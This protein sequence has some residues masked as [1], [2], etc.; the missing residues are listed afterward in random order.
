MAIPLGVFTC[1]TGVSGSG[2]STLVH[3]VVGANLLRR[4][5]EML[6][7][8]TG[9]CRAIEG[10]EH[11]GRVVLVDQSPL[12]RTPRSTP[13]VYIGVFDK[14]RD[15]FADLP[16]SR[17]AGLTPGTFSFNSSG[18]RCERCGGT[19]FEK[20]EMQF[21]SD[22]YVRCPECEGRR[23]QPFVL[24]IRHRDH[25][26][27]DI[28]EMTVSAAIR[29]FGDHPAIATPSGSWKRSALAICGWASRST[30]SA[31]ANPSGSNWSPIWAAEKSNPPAIRTSTRRA[32]TIPLRSLPSPATRFLFSTNPP[33]ACTSTTSRCS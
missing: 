9:K 7:R 1:V 21:L 18:G 20:V 19:G 2:K 16:E 27:H 5:G 3:D 30:P 23:Y 33:P 29:F 24:R 17:A 31:A 25:S 32:T 12:S 22:L 14:I 8:M 26:I 11:I 6:E 15:L 13:A 10:L 28:L 4:Q